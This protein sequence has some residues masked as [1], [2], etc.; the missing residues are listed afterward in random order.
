MFSIRLYTIKKEKK[1][2]YFLC[3]FTEKE[4]NIFA[5]LELDIFPSGSARTKGGFYASEIR[6]L[7]SLQGQKVQS[8]QRRTATA[9][10]QLRRLR[11]PVCLEGSQGRE[12]IIFSYRTKKPIS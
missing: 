7:G 11:R 12:V 5:G 2:K 9:G 4:Y 6:R 1:S 8:L 3:F 10:V